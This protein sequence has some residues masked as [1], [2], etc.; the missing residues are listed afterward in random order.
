MK[1]WKKP[2]LILS[3][4]FICVLPVATASA[5]TLKIK[6]DGK[7]QDYKG[8]QIKYQVNGK[9]KKYNTPGLLVNGTAMVGAKD[10]FQKALGGTYKYTSSSGK[11]V[12]KFNDNTVELKVGSKT[13]YINGKKDTLSVAPMKIYF[14]STKTTKIYVPSRF[15]SEGLGVDYKWNAGSGT[16]SLSGKKQAASLKIYYDGAWKTYTGTQGQVSVFGKVQSTKALPLLIIDN[17]TMIRANQIFKGALKLT[18]EYDSSEKTLLLTDGATT[19][20]FT[21]DSKT[22]YVDG[23]KQ[24][25]STEARVI[26]NADGD[27]YVMVPGE[28]TCEAFGLNYKWDSSKKTAYITE[29]TGEEPPEDPEEEDPEYEGLKI[30]YDGSWKDYTGTRGKVSVFGKKLSTGA[31]PSIIIDNT[32]LLR[33]KQVFATAMGAD[34]NYNSASKVLTLTLNGNTVIFTMNSDTAYVNGIAKTMDTKARVIKNEEGTGYVMVPGRFTANSLGYEYEWNASSGL[35]TITKP[36]SDNGGGDITVI[37][38]T[39]YLT[40]SPELS[41]AAEV[42]KIKG[43]K[44]TAEIASANTQTASIINVTEGASGQKSEQYIIRTSMPMGNISATANANGILSINL[45]N[46]TTSDEVYNYNNTLIKYVNTAGVSTSNSSVVYINANEAGKL[47][48]ELSLSPDRCSLT[49]TVYRDY[50]TEASAGATS[51]YE[52]VR[53]NGISS[54]DYDITNDSSHVYVTLKNTVNALGNVN[55]IIN[56]QYYLNNLM[57]IQNGNNTVITITKKDG[58]PFKATAMSDGLLISFY[59]DTKKSVIPL[60]TGVSYSSITDEDLYLKKRIQIKI[61][62]DYLSFYNANPVTVLGEN[63]TNTFMSFDGYNTVINIDCSRVQGYRLSQTDNG[64]GITIGDPDE[65]F[66]K[67]IVLDAGHGGTDPGS[68]KGGVNEKDVVQNILYTYGKEIFN[69]SDIKAYWTRTTDVKVDLYERAAFTEEVNADYFIS[70]H[71]N[72]YTGSAAVNGLEVYYSSNNNSPIYNGL[73]SKKMAEFIEER[74]P[75]MIDINHRTNPIRQAGYVV[76]KYNSVPAVLIEL[77]YMTNSSDLAKFKKE[78]FQRTTAQALF[79]VVE[80]LF[81]AYPTQR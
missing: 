68:V 4:L 65:I 39:V 61:P 55:Q 26:K 36:G 34:Y 9:S 19:V 3:L 43:L 76:T 32:A 31:M 22:A 77:G 15:V 38:T 79:D 71:L 13:A 10:V 41:F 57:I 48:Y 20:E 64:I 75:D 35:S 62:G 16:V 40:A 1:N 58:V 50:L 67:I 80:Q 74:L 70:L 27:G 81:A 7:K 69:S 49:V 52:Y 12:I 28:F 6:Y 2:L 53:L 73:T 37:P 63:V 30:Y 33:A 14:Y 25:M 78:S 23:E 66:D 46:T 44:D 56:S 5:A 45:A 24:T 17:T 8:T 11:I 29:N 47:T 51:T 21:M 59:E 72:S 18:Y 54:F 42:N 60:P